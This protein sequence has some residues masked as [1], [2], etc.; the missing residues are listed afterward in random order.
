M[1][2]N[3]NKSYKLDNDYVNEESNKSNKK[4]LKENKESNDL[5]DDYVATSLEAGFD[6]L[7]KARPPLL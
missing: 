5:R 3:N 2:D 6:D 4:Y 1:L 7:K